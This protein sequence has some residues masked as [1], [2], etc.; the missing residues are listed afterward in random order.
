MKNKLI[1]LSIPPDVTKENIMEAFK[2][3]GIEDEKVQYQSQ[4]ETQDE[5]GGR[6]FIEV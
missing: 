6:A 3:Y 2:D 5:R 4:E 1:L